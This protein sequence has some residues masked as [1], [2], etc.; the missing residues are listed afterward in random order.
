MIERNKLGLKEISLE[1][2]IELKKQIG[3]PSE[4][5]YTHNMGFCEIIKPLFYTSFYDLLC[6]FQDYHS[7]KKAS[8]Q[9]EGGGWSKA[10]RKNLDEDLMGG[11]EYLAYKN[12]FLFL[13]FHME[14]KYR[15]NEMSFEPVAENEKRVVSASLSIPGHL[16]EEYDWQGSSRWYKTIR[17]IYV[18]EQLKIV[19]SHEIISE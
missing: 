10:K 17:G 14:G 4:I 3:K 12:G 7:G 19:N 16:R 9:F 15:D 11:L 5:E 6:E 2:Y 8:I 18:P 1:V 13:S